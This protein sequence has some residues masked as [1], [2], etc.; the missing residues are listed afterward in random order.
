MPELESDLWLALM[1]P[2]HT[3]APIIDKVNREVIEILKAPAV[4]DTLIAQGAGVAYST[5]AELT[6]LMRSET[7]KWKKVIEIAGVRID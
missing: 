7:A 2:A 3:P 4:R 5:P 1:A 6:S